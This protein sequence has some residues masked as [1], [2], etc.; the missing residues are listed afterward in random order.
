[1]TFHEL[2]TSVA[3]PLRNG[4]LVFEAPWQGRVFALANSLSERGVF[5]WSEFQAALIQ[6][7]KEVTVSAD[8]P[9]AYYEHFLHA[10]ADLLNSKGVVSG[11]ELAH[12]VDHFAQREHGH[13]HHHY[14]HDPAHDPAHVHVHTDHD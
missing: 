11:K 6:E 14:P 4:E 1:M 9:Y 2:D 7:L 12:Q 5:E 3:P 8:Q 13:D 10:L